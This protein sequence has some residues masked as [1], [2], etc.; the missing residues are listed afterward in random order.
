MAKTISIFDP[1]EKPYGSLSNNATSYFEL[2]G[3]KWKT[4]THYLYSSLLHFHTFKALVRNQAKVREVRDVF[5]NLYNQEIHD[6]TVSAVYEANEVKFSNPELKKLLLAT[7]G[8]EIIYLSSDPIL[9]VRIEGEELIGD[10]ALGKS[11]MQIRAR[12]A[13]AVAKAEP[14]APQKLEDKIYEIYKAYQVLETYVNRDNRDVA[15]LEGLSYEEIINTRPQAASTGAGWVLESKFLPA[16]KFI[17]KAL[18]VELYNR[19]SFPIITKEV[20]NPG[21]LVPLFRQEFIGRINNKI[22]LNRQNVILKMFFNYWMNKG[23]P[24]DGPK[25]S[26]IPESKWGE[27]RTEALSQ[28]STSQ[29][30]SLRERLAFLFEKGMLSA[31]LSGEIDDAL[32][33]LPRPLTKEEIAKIK[34]F[35]LYKEEKEVRAEEE[36][37]KPQG[38]KIFIKE[39][40]NPPEIQPF[41]PYFH[42]PMEIFALEFPTVIHYILTK[43]LSIL[44]QFG[45]LGNAYNKMLIPGAAGVQ[46]RDIPSYYSVYQYEKDVEYVEGMEGFTVLGMDKKFAGHYSLQT[47]LLTTEGSMLEYTD[48]D[49]ILGTGPLPEKRGNNFVD[50]ERQGNNFVGKYLMKIRERVAKERATAGETIVK[51][52]EVASVLLGDVQLRQWMESRLIELCQTIGIIRDYF[53]TKYEY[54]YGVELTGNF[55]LLVLQNFYGDCFQ[56]Y[57]FSQKIDVAVPLEFTALLATCPGFD[58]YQKKGWKGLELNP[59]KEVLIQTI[60][61]YF[62]SMF[63]SLVKFAAEPTQV[64]VRRLLVVS[65]VELSKERPCAKRLQDRK[66]NC[67]LS[68]LINILAHLKNF[69]LEYGVTNFQINDRDILISMNILLNRLPKMPVKLPESSASTIEAEIVLDALKEIDPTVNTV[70]VKYFLDIVKFISVFRG[71]SKVTKQNRVNFF[72]E[73]PQL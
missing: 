8:Y 3:E 50:P 19:G 4:V 69:T 36:R 38:R 59:D 60:W 73:L 10:N 34:N 58:L 12:S 62:S 67:I 7:E 39:S 31:T 24:R 54:T 63:Y 43:L 27:A 66:D 64:Q 61:N 20:E 22:K 18:V 44:R 71:I 48:R 72:A 40:G 25:F 14:T 37:P 9:G 29:L 52:E 23:D 68:A 21:N 6:V 47:L 42:A 55:V 30:V 53:Q 5:L 41:S 49:L 33:N 16:P 1:K 57:N 46:F 28:L 17:D 13:V 35:T 45:A 26:T 70:V 65:E 2:D 32:A 11:L 56:L 51:I 15:S